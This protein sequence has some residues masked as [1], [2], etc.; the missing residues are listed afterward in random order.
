MKE[1][2]QVRPRP[3]TWNPDEETLAFLRL[4]ALQN[5]VEY[6]GQAVAGSVVG[7]IMGMRADLRP[8]GRVL[9]PAIATAV[10]EANA[11][12]A[13]E[14]LEA[15][16]EELA[17]LAPELL[18]SRPKAERRVGL[19]DLEGAKEGEVVLRFA[20]NPNGP[21]SFG[22]ARGLVINGAYA[23]RYKGI[24]ILRFDDTDTVVKPPM[25]EA[26]DT[27]QQETEWLLGRPADRVVIASDRIEL[28]HAHATTMIER[29]FG[30]VCTCSA[31]AFRE[32]RVAQQDCPC[33][34]GTTEVH[35]T[36]WEGMLNGAYRPGDAVVR[37]KTGMNQRNPALRDWPALRLQDTVANPHPRPEVGSKHQVWPLLD[38]QSAIEDHLQ[39]VTHIIRGKDLMDST[40][41]QTLLYEHFGWTYP[42]TMYWGRVKVH[43]WG[44]FSTS[45]M[46]KDI[47]SGR[48]E[49]WNDPRLPTLSALGRRGIQP[50]ALRT[51]WLE[52]AITQKDISVPLTSLFSHNTKA[53]DSTAPRLAFVRDPI[54][55]PLKDGPASATLVRYPDE[56]EKD[57]RQH[58]LASGHVLVESEDA[59]KSAFR[60]KDL[61]DV[62]LEDGVLH[63]GSTERQ[64]NRP[65]VHWTV[66][67]ALPTTLV[68]AEDDELHDVE[69]R[70][71]PH[72]HPIGTVF[73]LERV[74]YAILLDDGRLLMTHE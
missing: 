51:F 36:R 49:G 62:D 22:H 26:Y 38:F 56:P 33:R 32:F 20:P 1:L 52:L 55:L 74:G 66:D 5:A 47:E 12:V 19:P 63:A 15:A 64:D 18:E 8:H 28:Y 6:A 14:G 70:L 71:E 46:R 23:E 67:A 30:Y 40:R 7:R 54:R 72:D 50:E 17:S 34:D 41:K 57:P 31:E 2:P 24:L 48:Y 37:V 9:A 59:E 13:E 53:V 61:V 45:A 65:I 4:V 39:G 58:D 3:M 68:V 73:Q 69:G 60:L 21:L 44:G 42:K 35:V 43:E 10:A 25:P 29:G 16:Q 27:I 11:F